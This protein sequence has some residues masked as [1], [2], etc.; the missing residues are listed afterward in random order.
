MADK[1]V[2]GEVTQVA[3]VD[4]RRVIRQLHELIEALERRVPRLGEAGELR[5]VHDAA[6]LKRRAMERIAELRGG[7]AR[8]RGTGPGAP[9][10]ASVVQHDAEQ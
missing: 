4:R 5:I 6:A 1:D 2:M 3:E 9:G 10:D 7:S 8:D